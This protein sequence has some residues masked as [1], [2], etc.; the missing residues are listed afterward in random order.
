MDLAVD[1][2]RV[3][4]WNEVARIFLEGIS[5]GHATFETHVPSWD[6]WNAGHIPGSGLVVRA[7][8]TVV[9]WA[10]LSPTSTRRVYA[11]VAEVTMYVTAGLRGKGIGHELLSRLIAL[12]ENLGVWTLQAVVFPEN[13]ASVRLHGRLG[14]REVG[15]RERIGQM[16][17]VWRDVILLE[18]RS[19]SVGT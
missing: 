8:A 16:N 4:D 5:T 2:M 15:R 12:S 17:G 9:G 19:Q 14:F 7:G 13:S 10:A 11:G 3:E 1:R 6:E 18:R